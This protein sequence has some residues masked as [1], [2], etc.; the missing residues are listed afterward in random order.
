MNKQEERLFES[1]IEERLD[2]AAVTSLKNSDSWKEAIR[3]RK[4]KQ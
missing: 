3:Y 1:K 4:S 2:W